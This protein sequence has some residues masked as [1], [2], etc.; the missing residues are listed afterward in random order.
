MITITNQVNRE[1][2]DQKVTVFTSQEPSTNAVDVINST[3]RS[4]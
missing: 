2:G 4:I 1:N 3:A